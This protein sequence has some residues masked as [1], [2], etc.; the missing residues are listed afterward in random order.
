MFLH[1]ASFIAW[2]ALMAVHVLG[3]VLELPSLAMPDWRRSGGRE[4]AL[5]GSGLRLVLLGTSVVAGLALALA[6]IS[7]ADPWLSASLGG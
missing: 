7:I 6:T 1:K 3:H 4:A 2:F 5:A